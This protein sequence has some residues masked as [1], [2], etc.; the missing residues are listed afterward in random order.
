MMYRRGI[1]S[2]VV[3]GVIIAPLNGCVTPSLAQYDQPSDVCNT[4]RQ[5]LLETEKSFNQNVAGGVLL[6]ALAGAAIGLATGNGGRAVAIGA[7]AGAMAGGTAGYLKAKQERGATQAALLAEIDSDA[8]ADANFFRTT[9]GT[10]GNLTDCRSSQIAAVTDAFHKGTIA[11]EEAQRRLAE[12]QQAVALDKELL[13]KVLEG[14]GRRADMYVD[15]RA[16]ATGLSREQIVGKAGEVRPTD[17]L[18]GGA[19]AAGPARS[20]VSTASSNVRGAPSTSAHIVGGLKTGQK[21]RV[22]SETRNGWYQVDMNG[23]PGYV[24]GSLLA[25]AGTAAAE[26]AVAE[27]ARAAAQRPAARV[28]TASTAPTAGDA[29]AVADAEAVVEV[30]DNVQRT[31]LLNTQVEAQAEA[32]GRTMDHQMQLAMMSVGGP[33]PEAAPAS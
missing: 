12:I 24:H 4:Y 23:I 33:A 25:E 29:V 5:P 13:G 20:F 21:V 30:E 18:V 27:A 28:E 19:T 31:V 11:R 10:I 6:G 8:M 1:A 26:T 7:A 22:V 9:S 17:L 32:Y 16:Q 2:I 3:A 15:A 14:T